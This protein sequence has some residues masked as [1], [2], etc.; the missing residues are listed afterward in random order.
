MAY[1]RKK[2]KHGKIY[3]YLVESRRVGPKK[4]PREHIL[5]YI[6]TADNLV[7]F[8]N[9]QMSLNK[10]S[11]TESL[12]DTTFKS[13]EYGASIA[14][15]NV[16]DLLKVK[17]IFDTCF[18]S[19]S[20]HDMSRSEI[21]VYEIIHRIVDPG[22]KRAFSKWAEGSS[23]PY[24]CKFKPEDI[25]SQAIWEAMDDITEDEVLK[26]QRL[27]TKNA[28]EIY[29]DDLNTLHLD[30]TNYYTYI[31]SNNNACVICKRGHNKQKRNDLRQ[32]GLAVVTSASLQIP[33][34]WE[35][36]EGN[37]SDVREFSDF[38]ELL[39]LEL[40]KQ[41][42][43]NI[44]NSILT[45]DGGSNSKHNFANLKLSFICAHSLT[46]L[47]NLYDIDVDKY[48]KITLKNN[49]ERKAYRIDNLEFSDMKGTGILTFSQDLYNGQTAQLNKDIKKFKDT[50]E[51]IILTSD[52]PRGKLAKGLKAALKEY[53]KEVA[54]IEKDNKKLKEDKEKGLPVSKD[55]FEKEVPKWNEK[56]VL[57]KFILDTATENNKALK[58]FV[59]VDVDIINDDSG[60]KYIITYSEDEDKK[61][62]Y[63]KRIFG[64]KLICTNK[65]DLT[66]TEILSIYSDQE[67]IE[68]MFKSSKKNDHFSVRPQYHWTDQ[69]IIVHVMLCMF[70]IT[71]AEVMRRIFNDKDISYTKEGLIDKLATIRDGWIIKDT[72]QVK[73]TIE[74]STDEQQAMIDIIQSIN[75][76]K[77]KKR[78]S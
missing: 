65:T 71:I 28:R 23:L 77:T 26:A 73:R 40:E 29:G 70:A 36:Y 51:A 27:L 56:E 12:N 5:E 52:S 33:I 60:K 67:C 22:S 45:F 18:K 50:C 75:A 35:T 21:L 76:K 63:I 58:S 31:D 9:Q 25:T 49:H 2:E 4:Q 34:V 78:K 30:Y 66:T 47:K 64:K 68:N 54:L 6:G 42:V 38:T 7:K 41:G 39:A 62:E 15:K 43:E 57:E 24:Y 53:N 17:S 1:I 20:V 19:K 55:E 48:D 44:S 74:S 69:K 14:A 46:G 72:K 10:K 32:F 16:C 37:K 59:S 13:Y 8:I 11:E 61:N 3:Y